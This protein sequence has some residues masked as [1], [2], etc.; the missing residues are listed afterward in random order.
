MSQN[1]RLLSHLKIA[2]I[3]PFDAWVTLG[4]YRL[5]A[6]IND[7]KMQGYEIHSKMVT[8][9]NRFGEKFRVAEYTL[10]QGVSE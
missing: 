1:E 8:V 9:V 4:I 3:T 5:A 7:L 6:R 10:D 2:P